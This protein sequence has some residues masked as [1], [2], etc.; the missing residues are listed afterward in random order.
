MYRD[1]VVD[2]D[3]LGEAKSG[4]KVQVLTTRAEPVV[5]TIM[6]TD[7]RVDPTTRNASVRATVA[8]ARL[9]PHDPQNFPVSR[10]CAPHAGQAICTITSV[11]RL[12]NP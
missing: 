4:D 3:G 7:A 11:P 12:R 8:D 2:K 1:I 10:F 6:A 5:A 9:A